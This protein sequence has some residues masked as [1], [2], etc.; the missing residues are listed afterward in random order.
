MEFSWLGLMQERLRPLQKVSDYLCCSYRIVMACLVSTPD[1]W[2]PPNAHEREVDGTD[3]R[4]GVTFR[5]FLFFVVCPKTPMLCF[6]MQSNT[7]APNPDLRVLSES[8]L[9]P[10][11]NS[12]AKVIEQQWT[13]RDQDG[14][15][16]KTADAPTIAELLEQHGRE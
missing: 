10:F 9:K 15:E 3:S 5:F 12:L 4:F 16:S 1:Q 6:Q 14:D 11:P 2:L 7:S 8:N 13:R